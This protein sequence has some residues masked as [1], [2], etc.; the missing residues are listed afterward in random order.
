MEPSRHSTL[1]D[2]LEGN[3]DGL[4]D[5]IGPIQDLAIPEAQDS[6][7]SRLQPGSTPVVLLDLIGVLAAVHLDQQPNL[8]QAKSAT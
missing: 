3:P 6:E 4:D 2:A 7:A 1:P 5:I 8:R